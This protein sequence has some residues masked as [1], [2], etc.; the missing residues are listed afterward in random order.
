VGIATGYNLNDRGIGVR[1]PLGATFLSSAHR[2]DGSGALPASY[3]MDTA[4][5]FPG[6]KAAKT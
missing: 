2:P 3:I 6:A 4:G 1:V 5:S